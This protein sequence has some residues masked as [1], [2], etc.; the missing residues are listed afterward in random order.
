LYEGAF[1][2]GFFLSDAPEFER[3]VDH[4]RDRL[5]GSYARALESLAE[6]AEASL[7]RAAA[8]RWW[9]ARAALDPFDSRVARRLIRALDA[10]GNPAAALQHAGIHERLLQDEFGVPPDRETLELVESIRQRRE[11]EKPAPASSVAAPAAAP[12]AVDTEHTASVAATGQI[13]PQPTRRFAAGR[14][15]AWGA[16]ALL[17]LL[18]LAAVLSR[19]TAERAGGLDGAAGGPTGAGI[20]PLSTVSRQEPPARSIAVLP[21]VNL[22]DPTEEY[23]SDGLAEELI[24]ALARIGALRV[25][26]RTSSFAFKGKTGDVREIGEALNVAAVLEGSV[27]RDGDRLVVMAQLIDAADG[28]HMWSMT[29][30]RRITEVFELQRDL[31]SQIAAALEAELTPAERERLAARPTEHVEAFTWYLRARHFWNQ[32]TPMGYERAIDYF[33]RATALDPGYAEAWAGLAGVHSL[34][35]LAGAVDADSARQLSRIAALRAIELDDGIAEAHTALGLYLHAYE[36]NAP[37]AQREF[38]K[39]IAL[40]PGDA[41]AR[42][43]YGNLLGAI[44]RIDDAIAQ[45]EIAAELDPL[46]PALAE[47]LAYTLVRAGRLDEAVRQVSWAIEL[48]S[49]YWRAYAVLG[50]IHEKAGEADDAILAY[51]RANALAGAGTH[52]TQADIARVLTTVGR[53]DEAR[54]HV[55]MLRTDAIR[56]GMHEPAV[57]TALHSLGEIDAAFDWLEQGFRERHPHLAFIRGDARF[58]A[59]DHEPRFADLLRR[60]GI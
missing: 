25:A 34:Q 5:A 27:R 48:D 33:Q 59:F 13:T 58:A 46:L 36:W 35:G 18:M 10:A 29:Y 15:V 53:R 56:A 6:T 9:K 14:L 16:A 30:E 49:T 44:G 43:M 47:T 2:D 32:R 19:R 60:I 55:A 22:S 31:A 52:R 21:F 12:A 28:L 11:S 39:A 51:E 45:K 1:L 50:L 38:L 24:G 23:L 4:E 54:R 37:A 57:A 40:N 7:D 42:Q 26:A 20:E 3:W 17:A 41:H 8:M